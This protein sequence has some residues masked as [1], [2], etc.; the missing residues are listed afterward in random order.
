[1]DLNF[2]RGFFRLWIAFSFV[3]IAFIGAM[4]GPSYLDQ[5]GGLFQ[6]SAPAITKG[7]NPYDRL[8]REQE[9]IN[10]SK[11]AAQPERPQNERGYTDEEVGIVPAPGTPLFDAAKAFFGLPV[12]LL[13][14]GMA[15]RWI[16]RGFSPARKVQ[17]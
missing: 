15:V 8:D 12:A 16:I 3:W 6:H 4:T 9:P 13:V 17:H 14:A 7:E 10:Q 1:M 5:L 2:G 11:R